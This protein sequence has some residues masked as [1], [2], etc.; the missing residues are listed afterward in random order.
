LTN[1]LKPAT[2]AWIITCDIGGATTDV[3]LAVI[4]TEDGVLAP[5]VYPISRNRN[6]DAS[7]YR[8][9]KKFQYWIVEFG[10]EGEGLAET[11]WWRH[12]RHSF[13]GSKEVLLP[14]HSVKQN[15]TSSGDDISSDRLT[16]QIP[17]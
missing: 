17:M 5:E 12:A 16:I 14:V 6:G 10:P 7:V 1:A 9:D 3:A 13:D 15:I 8:I 11:L 2:G 4:K